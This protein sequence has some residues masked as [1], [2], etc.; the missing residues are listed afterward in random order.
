M[1]SLVLVQDHTSGCVPCFGKIYKICLMTRWYYV[2]SS[3]G[4]AK[5]YR[6]QRYFVPYKIGIVSFH[7]ETTMFL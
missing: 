2:S 6:Y 4:R 5:N 7:S 3:L 1:T